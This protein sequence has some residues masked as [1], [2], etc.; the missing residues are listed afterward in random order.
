MPRQWQLLVVLAACAGWAGCGEEVDP[1]PESPRPAAVGKA[2]VRAVAAADPRACES[3]TP[4]AAR[5]AATYGGFAS[6]EK[7]IEAQTPYVDRA[8]HRTPP[9]EL[10]EGLETGHLK[11]T[12]SGAEYRFCTPAETRVVLGL[13]EGH[14]GW[15]VDSV[16]AFEKTVNG[17]ASACNRAPLD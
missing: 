15:T 8:F 4:E 10:T 7:A 12:D 11:T 6:C 16:L 3:L 5:L 17:E 2:F 9:S 13:V 14:D 1:R